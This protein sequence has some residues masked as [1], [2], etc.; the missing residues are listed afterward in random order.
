MAWLDRFRQGSFRG[1]EFFVNSHQF[2][3]GRQKVDHEFPQ[4]N[5]NKSEDVGLKT[6][7]FSLEM[8]IIGDD[9]F[10]QRDSLVDALE[11]EGAGELIHPYLGRKVVQVGGFSL[12]ETV[13]EGRVARFSVEFSEAGETIFP[14]SIDDEI[15]NGISN[16][17][18]MIEDSKTGFQQ[19]YSVAGQASYVVQAAADTITDTA[20]FMEKSVAKFTAPIADLSFAISNLKAESERLS[21]LPGELADRIAETFDLLFTSFEDDPETSELILGNFALLGDDFDVVTGTTPS[22]DQQRQNEDA[23]VNM[24]KQM[25]IANQSKSAFNITYNSTNQ[26]IEI[27]DNIAGLIDDQILLIENDSLY[28][29]A[30]DLKSSLVN[31]LPPEGITDLITYEPPVTMPAIVLAHQLFQDL[32]KEQEIIDQNNIEHP[33]FV[34]GG[35]EIEVASG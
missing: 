29:S 16:A 24:S 32:D 7:V 35:T 20:N 31:A 11:K 2:A 21:R 26:A 17:D 9:Y 22:R 5:K 33:A 14:E 19:L 6:R 8:Y 23:I 27:R 34:P 25:A 18:Q 13:D 1:I 30:K 3:G 28:Q 10:T 15:Q 12:K 4:R